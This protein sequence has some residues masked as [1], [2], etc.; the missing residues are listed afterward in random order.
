MPIQALRSR[1]HG[2]SGARGTA[3]KIGCD[4]LVGVARCEPV[5]SL[6]SGAD[7]AASRVRALL[8]PVL[9]PGEPWRAI[10]HEPR[11]HDAPLERRVGT[12]AE[13]VMIRMTAA[14]CWLL[15]PFVAGALVG[16]FKR[17]LDFVS[18]HFGL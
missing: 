11:S 15:S 4:R 2:R 5:T 10:H 17:A 8:R 13:A 12:V 14:L 16:H 7:T 3:G 9:R 1:C 6:R 18:H